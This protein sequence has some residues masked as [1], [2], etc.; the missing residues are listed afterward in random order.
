MTSK[1]IDTVKKEIKVFAST[2]PR[3]K[4]LIEQS[5]NLLLDVLEPLIK[6]Q[7]TN[8]EQTTLAA[9]TAAVVYSN[10]KLF[11]INDEQAKVAARN[12]A[13]NVKSLGVQTLR[14]LEQMKN[15]KKEEV[16]KALL[17]FADGV[18]KAAI[19][20]LQNYPEN[21]RI[22]L[23]NMVSSF[24]LTKPKTE[25]DA[26]VFLKKIGEYK[27]QQLKG[28]ISFLQGATA[29]LGATAALGGLPTVLGSPD[30]VNTTT[31][32]YLPSVTNSSS[33]Y[34]PMNLT[35]NLPSLPQF[36]PMNI[37]TS[38][39]AS[40]GTTLSDTSYYGNLANTTHENASSPQV[41][42]TPASSSTIPGTNPRVQPT[43]SS[44]FWSNPFSS[45][46]NYLH[47]SSSSTENT[48][49]SSSALI[50]PGMNTEIVQQ[51]FTKPGATPVTID[52]TFKDVGAITMHGH[53]NLAP[54]TKEAYSKAKTLANKVVYLMNV[55]NHNEV[56]ENTVNSTIISEVLSDAA[57]V[58]SWF[59]TRDKSELYWINPDELVTSYGNHNYPTWLA[60]TL[61]K[62]LFA[63][64]NPLTLAAPITDEQVTQLANHLQPAV[65][66]PSIA[67]GVLR[68]TFI[69]FNGRNPMILLKARNGGTMF[70][71]VQ[72]F[73]K[74]IDIK[75]Q[76]QYIDAITDRPTIALN[77]VSQLTAST[78]SE[79]NVSTN[80][81][82]NDQVN[83]TI[84]IDDEMSEQMFLQGFKK[85]TAEETTVTMTNNF[86]GV[87]EVKPTL[88]SVIGDT[89]DAF[90][91]FSTKTVL[92]LSKDLNASSGLRQTVVTG[93][94]E[95]LP[96]RTQRNIAKTN[97]TEFIAIETIKNTVEGYPEYLATVL[98]YR[99]L[100]LFSVPL[101][102]AGVILLGER[103]L[104]IPLF[105]LTRKLIGGG[106]NVV[107]WGWGSLSGA[108]KAWWR[109]ATPEER[110]LIQEEEITKTQQSM[111]KHADEIGSVIQDVGNAVLN[112]GIQDRNKQI[113]RARMGA[114]FLQSKLPK[115]VGRLLNPIANMQDKKEIGAS[116]NVA[117]AIRES[118]KES[119]QKK[120]PTTFKPPKTSSSKDD[121][122]SVK[123]ID[124]LMKQLKESVSKKTTAPRQRQTARKLRTKVVPL[125]GKP[126]KK[127]LVQRKNLVLNRRSEQE[128]IPTTRTRTKLNVHRSK[129]EAERKLR[130]RKVTS[131]LLPTKRRRVN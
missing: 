117:N 97:E 85:S 110:Q 12:T 118:L 54:I 115:S 89:L 38:P 48:D 13:L 75:E 77:K 127:R 80:V 55:E 7:Q 36:G 47:P 99:K 102:V 91:K 119:L 39:I 10:A 2:D 56:R 52:Q 98:A 4:V 49:S 32:D 23:K 107:A 126:K 33:N 79:G 27:K 62:L 81:I 123:K 17:I 109:G 43:D 128:Q 24:I 18:G 108:F 58:K 112:Q 63:A 69:D 106:L 9:S 73:S 34:A 101:P 53:K 88:G 116:F 57:R 3:A 114:K 19:Q 26:L 74:L 42:V 64:Q 31:A 22:M 67:P 35:T 90:D 29:L 84:V 87:R 92:E 50:V 94:Y 61:P 113:A 59:R 60:L 95:S 129:P 122:V 1:T 30:P 8:E 72:P 105:A 37:L 46:Y 5:I 100:I 82:Q 104:R 121:G 96:K 124:K 66:D 11:G 103:L 44:S 86:Y 65:E 93:V 41:N 70:M 14:Y 83:G 15:P 131:S 51:H 6:E 16:K 45:F 68:N 40:N 76:K 120:P 111:L 78:K 28:G 125:K 130:Q 25:Y 21:T 71:T 20:L